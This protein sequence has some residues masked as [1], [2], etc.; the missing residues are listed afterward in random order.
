MSIELIKVPDI[1]GTKGVEVIEICV[2]VGD[3]V[4]LE[5]SLVVLESDKASMEVPSPIAG[6]VTSIKISDGDELS[7]GD[8]ILELDTGPVLDDVDIDAVRS[9]VLLESESESESES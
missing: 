3:Q 2:A 1:G 8:V 7:E 5:Q 4:E 9:E 6:T